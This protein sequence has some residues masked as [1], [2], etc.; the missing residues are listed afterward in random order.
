[1]QTSKLNSCA[2]KKGKKLKMSKTEAVNVVIQKHTK[3]IST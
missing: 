1:M 3:S 2:G